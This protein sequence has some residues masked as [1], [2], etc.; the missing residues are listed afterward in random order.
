MRRMRNYNLE[1]RIAGSSCRP[2]LL[3]PWRTL[4]AVSHFPQRN[5]RSCVKIAAREVRWDAFHLP[6]GWRFA[7][8][9]ANLA[10]SAHP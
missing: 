8:S 3:T 7:R 5:L 10:R 2:Q 1:N 4:Q 9:L 6:R